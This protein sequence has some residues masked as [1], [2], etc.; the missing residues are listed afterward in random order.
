MK[1]KIFSF[2]FGV[3][4]FLMCLLVA[5][6]A[7]FFVNRKI[8]KRLFWGPV[9]IINNKYWSNAMRQAGFFSKTFMLEYYASINKRSDFDLYIEDI[10]SAKWLPE[11]FSK[12]IAVYLSAMVS[13][14]QFDVHH[15]SYEG[16]FLGLTPFWRFE[17]FVLRL[18]RIKTV[19]MP[20]GGDSYIYSRL[21]DWSLKHAL[22]L[23]YPKAAVDECKILGK[24]DLWQKNA[25]VVVGSFLA[26]G[27]SR[28]DVLTFNFL[29]I[30]SQKIDR[31]DRR[32]N[33]NLV[34]VVH[35]PNHRGFK[36]TEFLCAAID[37]LKNEGYSVE[38]VLLEK[39][40]NDE[41]IRILQEEADILA[42][43]FIATGYAMSALEGMMAGLP[44][45]SNLSGEAQTRVFRRYTYLN[46]CPIV[47]TNP[48]T[49]YENLKKLI[50][51]PTLRKLL[52][53][54]G[55]KYVEKYHSQH[56]AV[57]LFTKIYEFLDGNEDSLANLFHPIL[58]DHHKTKPRVEHPL[59]E[60]R[61]VN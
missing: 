43:Q 42:E 7:R 11:K 61:I 51:N 12:A 24:V 4:F 30:D 46:E 22:L 45:L 26:D 57:Y 52:G 50:E 8:P 28:W 21:T 35:T 59:V 44:V 49:L 6:Y 1:K 3:P 20:Y 2:V 36:G 34:K 13:I 40:S 19:V 18:A 16:G 54:A 9:P 15:I 23:S 56:T 5:L 58:G 53:E 25:D 41:V 10:F 33:D 14:L 47:S 48:E 55:R 39:I 17:P 31:V 32:K 27:I 38:L 29:T 60:N 37:R